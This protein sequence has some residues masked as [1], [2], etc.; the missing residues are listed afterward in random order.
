MKASH[1]VPTVRKQTVLSDDKHRLRVFI[2]YSILSSSWPNFIPGMPLP[3]PLTELKVNWRQTLK[4]TQ[5]LILKRQNV[6]SVFLERLSEWWAMPCWTKKLRMM[7]RFNQTAWRHL[8]VWLWKD[9]LQ[10]CPNSGLPPSKFHDWI[11]CN[12]LALVSHRK[13]LSKCIDLLQYHHY[14]YILSLSHHKKH[15][16][17]KFWI[18]FNAIFIYFYS[19]FSKY[20]CNQL[21]VHDWMQTLVFSCKVRYTTCP[22]PSPTSITLCFMLCL[23]FSS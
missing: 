14:C 10:L 9:G 20:N 5:C 19:V 12:G 7:L 22:F 13:G 21:K 1:F 18:M 15:S 17:A 8:V 11:S 6:G 4:G 16:S 2:V 3:V 23:F